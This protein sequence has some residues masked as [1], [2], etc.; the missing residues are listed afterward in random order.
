MPKGPSYSF[1]EDDPGHSRIG[2][3]RDKARGL[4]GF[5][6]GKLVRGLALI[7]SDRFDAL[8]VD[9]WM[10]ALSGRSSQLFADAKH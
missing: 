4:S 3:A 8:L 10:P 2:P 1:S 9:N 6:Y 5:C 7:A